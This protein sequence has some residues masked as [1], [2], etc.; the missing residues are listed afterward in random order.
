MEEGDSFY[1]LFPNISFSD[2]NA[3]KAVDAIYAQSTTLTWE[4]IAIEEQNRVLDEVIKKRHDL[5]T[6]QAENKPTTSSP[7][8]PKKET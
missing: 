4:V 2:I 8:S 5:D 7:P 6:W 3:L 1:S